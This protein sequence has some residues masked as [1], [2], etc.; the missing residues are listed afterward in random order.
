[1]HIVIRSASPGDAPTLRGIE[2]RTGGRFH[3]VGMPDVADDEPLPIEVLARYAVAQ[4]AWVA[5]NDAD[6]PIGYVLVDDIDGNAHV[7]QVSVEPSHQGQGVGRALIEHVGL[8]AAERGMFAIT[9]TTFT[10]VPWNAPLYRRLGFRAL[11]DEDIGPGLR[12]IRDAE[13]AH[14]L[15]PATRTCMRR[16]LASRADQAL[17]EQMSA[18]HPSSRAGGR[19]GTG[20]CAPIGLR[21]AVG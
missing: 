20:T 15:D 6:C 21:D 9:L 16:E 12:A 18:E 4:R 17:A 3:E 13:S 14:G 5:L 2:R 7:E 19:P 8:W 10:D 11:A 1:V